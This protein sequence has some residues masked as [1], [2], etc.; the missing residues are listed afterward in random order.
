MVLFP[1]HLYTDLRIEDV[2]ET[3]IQYTLGILD[4]VKQKNYRAAFIRI[5][6]GKRWYYSATTELENLQG[7]IDALAAMATA[8]AG[9]LQEPVVQRLS[10]P[11]KARN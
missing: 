6:D 8:N 1:E 4:E 11:A 10:F 7:E 3:K 2:A 9:I 5:F